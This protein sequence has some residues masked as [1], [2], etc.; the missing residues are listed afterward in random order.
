MKRAFRASGW[1]C[2]AVG[3]LLLAPRSTAWAHRSPSAS[4]PVRDKRAAARGFIERAS[5][6]PSRSLLHA[7]DTP[8][9]RLR[10]KVKGPPGDRRV[11]GFDLKTPDKRENQAGVLTSIVG[12]KPS[13]RVSMQPIPY[14][15][16]K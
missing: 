12:S 9:N 15:W 13:R 4:G 1:L 5:F 2:A 6:P 3:L 10:L 7:L 14:K 16:G 8:G 11:V